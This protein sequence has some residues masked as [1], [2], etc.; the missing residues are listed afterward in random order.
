MSFQDKL[1]DFFI[2]KGHVI[3]ASVTQGSI[4]FMHWH[5]G[6]DISN[7]VQQTVNWFYL[8]LAG[9]FGASQ[10]WPDKD[11]DGIPDAQESHGALKD[12][13]TPVNPPAPAP[14]PGTGSNQ[15]KG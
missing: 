5:Y 7:N 6:K 8:F 12:D 2:N 10:V 3:L 15:S 1:W 4:L 9:H 14:N 13:G 11:N